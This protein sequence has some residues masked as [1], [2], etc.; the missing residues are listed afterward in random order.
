MH[1]V[2][3][4]FGG[5]PLATIEDLNSQIREVGEKPA[6]MK[7]LRSGQPQSLQV[8][9]TRRAGVELVPSVHPPLGTVRFLD[10]VNSPPN[11]VVGQPLTFTD[12][13][14]N[15]LLVA[16]FPQRDARAELAD[17]VKEVRKL[18]E[19]IDALDRSLKSADEKAGKKP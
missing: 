8:T 6:T 2:L 1:D 12:A 3:V 14:A 10:A 16:S 11:F 18:S 5:K 9:P 7:L 15:Q 13:A 19:R 4:E 17:L